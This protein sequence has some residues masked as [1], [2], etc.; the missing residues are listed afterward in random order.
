MRNISKRTFFTLLTFIFALNI[1]AQNKDDLWGIGFGLNAVDFY[2][3]NLS[4][5]ETEN[6]V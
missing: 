3:A 1:N 4:G 2:P 5:M 6:G